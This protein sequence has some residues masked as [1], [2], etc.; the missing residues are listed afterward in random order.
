MCEVELRVIGGIEGEDS[1]AT[2]V[3][4]Q[5]IW[6]GFLCEATNHIWSGSLCEA[7]GRENQIPDKSRGDF[8]ASP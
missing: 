4:S 6:S 2:D 8:A 3:T 5:D 1:N 7:I